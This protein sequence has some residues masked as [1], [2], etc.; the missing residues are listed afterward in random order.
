MHIV[1]S[2]STSTSY[3]QTNTPPVFGVSKTN[4]D[5][6]FEPIIC[7]P[8]E[9]ASDCDDYGEPIVDS[10]IFHIF[11]DV[12]NNFADEE[13]NP[14]SVDVI[15]SAIDSDISIIKAALQ[16]PLV[17]DIMSDI[18]FLRKLLLSSTL[19]VVLTSLIVTS[20]FSSSIAFISLSVILPFPA[21]SNAK[22]CTFFSKTS[23]TTFNPNT[24]LTR[25]MLV[26]ILH[27]MEGKPTV[28]VE[29]KFK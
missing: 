10:V 15:T 28:N 14:S 6:C 13:E 20:L 7:N 22:T 3:S 17:K 27:R 1:C 16:T 9:E 21:F 18:S 29:N 24:K 8:E 5:M 26:T 2:S 4:A 25:G 11:G 12:L 19:T 23:D